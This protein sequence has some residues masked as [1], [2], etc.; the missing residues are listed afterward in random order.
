MTL[1]ENKQKRNYFNEDA[2]PFL[3][4]KKHCLMKLLLI[5]DCRLLMMFK[6]CYYGYFSR[7]VNLIRMVGVLWG[8]LRMEIVSMDLKKW[9]E[10][11]FYCILHVKSS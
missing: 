8:F 6:L 11:D 4:D 1:H 10:A 5:F 2:S 7:V 9:N 3:C